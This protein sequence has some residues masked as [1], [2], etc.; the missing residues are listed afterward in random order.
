MCE[1][2]NK[3]SSVLDQLSPYKDDIHSYHL[4]MIFLRLREQRNKIYDWKTS[5]VGQGV[6]EILN[7]LLEELRQSC[8]LSYFLLDYNELSTRKPDPCN[9]PL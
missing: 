2:I 4:K 5:S 7:M 3:L 9:L 6:L 8:V 1:D